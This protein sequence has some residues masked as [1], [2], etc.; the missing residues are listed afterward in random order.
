MTLELPWLLLGMRLGLDG[1]TRVFLALTLVLWLAAAIFAAGHLAADPRRGRFWL[2]FVAAF[3]GNLGLVFARD[4]VSFYAFFALMT[5]AAYGLVV[6]AGN[7]EA[8]RAGRVYIVLAVLGEAS[9]LAG[10][11]LAAGGASGLENEHLRAAAAVSPHRDLI[12]ALLGAGF[13]VKAGLLGLHVWLPL[14]HPVAPAP[15]SAVLSGAMIKAGL[16]GWLQFLPLGEAALPDWGAA[17][18]AIGLAAAFYGALVGLMQD[19]AKVVLAYS[20]I[21][22]MGLMTVAVGA[23]LAAPGGAGAGAAVAAATFYAL[24]HGLAKG[25]LFLGTGIAPGGR[26]P[27]L[28]AALLVPALSLAGLPFTSG[29]AAKHALKAAM[30]EWHAVGPLLSLAAIGTA[31][32]M[33]R[34]AILA[35]RAPQARP[36]RSRLALGA[37]LACI[38]A[39]LAAAAWPMAGDAAGARWDDLWPALAGAGLAA[40]GIWG[41]APWRGWRISPGDMLSLA[42][43]LAPW[44]HRTVIAASEA[45]ERAARRG[46][47]TLRARLQV[48]AQGAR[49]RAAAGEARLGPAASLLLIALVA[50][51]AY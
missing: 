36:A 16:L 35:H 14:A 33:A 32:L 24:H 7:A 28:Y 11:L 8:R 22:Q 50:L 12:V 25:A 40:L 6:H 17:F 5:F 19:D 26:R 1:T 51:L 18:A 9:L 27:L 47:G 37:W 31:V 29:A 13:G 42:A 30:P 48:V 38:A 10:L 46:F 15:A 34:F 39:S 23:A 44:A 45:L 49:A 3:T 41:G 2:F 20:S 21:S 4:A 43:A